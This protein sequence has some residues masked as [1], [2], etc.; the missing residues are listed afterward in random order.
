MNFKY[1]FQ[2]NGDLHAHGGSHYFVKPIDGEWNPTP[3][4][5]LLDDLESGA[6]EHRQYRKAYEKH[7]QEKYLAEGVKNYGEKGKN[8]AA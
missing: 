8:E 1:Q 7:R 2:M 4:P 6:E 3:P 5:E